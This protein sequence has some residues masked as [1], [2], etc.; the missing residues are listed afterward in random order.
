[1]I[2]TVQLY[3]YLIVEFCLAVTSVKE[4][5]EKYMEMLEDKLHR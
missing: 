4:N 2:K 5:A 1:M 3:R